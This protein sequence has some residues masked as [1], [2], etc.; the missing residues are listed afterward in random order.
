[1]P[2]PLVLPKLRTLNLVPVVIVGRHLAPT[3]T[4][5]LDHLHVPNFGTRM[6]MS[7]LSDVVRTIL[8]GILDARYRPNSLRPLNWDALNELKGH[9]VSTMK[10]SVNDV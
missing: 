4:L 8:F 3:L 9:G 1:M 5:E 6:Q 7:S 10:F 2:A